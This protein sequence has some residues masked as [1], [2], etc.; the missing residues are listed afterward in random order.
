MSEITSSIHNTS[1][2]PGLSVIDMEPKVLRALKL[3]LQD[4]HSSNCP[5]PHP[6][7]SP[8]SHT[9]KLTQLHAYA[10]HYND[11]IV[12]FHKLYKVST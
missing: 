8:T 5:L 2:D 9:R 7:P 10:C 1:V 11:V 3:P 6:A 12:P 4:K